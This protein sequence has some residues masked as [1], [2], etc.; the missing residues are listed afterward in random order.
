MGNTMKLFLIN[1]KG[2]LDSINKL[3]FK[4]QEAY[5]VADE[6]TL[7]IWIGSDI[8]LIRQDKIVK[9]ARRLNKE[10]GG[11]A[12]LLLMNQGREYGAFSA[13]MDM[14]KAGVKED[15]II[16][17]RPELKLEK[18]AEPERIIEPEV[19]KE[20]EA[21]ADAVG[22]FTQLGQYRTSVPIQ[23][24]DITEVKKEPEII[25]EPEIPKKPKIEKVSEETVD[26]VGW[27][28]QVVKHRTAG[29][30]EDGSEAKEEEEMIEFDEYV[31]VGAYYLSQKGLSYDDLCWVLA[32]K[33]LIIQKGEENVID[34]EIRV[35]AEAA[36]QTSCTYD[37][38]CWLISE[39]T[40]LVAQ[41][42]L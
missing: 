39:F 18:P 1:N 9:R 30:V 34:D 2:E 26:V 28:T 23:E 4:E 14:L 33:Q 35:R 29:V 31:R 16:E 38:L 12:K 32:E 21:K 5:I 13:M 6:N 40:T 10:K 25:D 7:F 27:L 19:V 36:F 41:H 20:L 22:W 24:T 42:Y 37:E 11:A 17:R 3:D 8:S 15:E